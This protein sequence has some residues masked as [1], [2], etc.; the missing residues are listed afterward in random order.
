MKKMIF[1]VSLLTIFAA[2]IT[3]CGKKCK[4]CHA[5]IMGVEGPAQELCGDDLKKAEKSG[6]I[7]CE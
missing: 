5:T 1:I 6:A 7:T 4:T 3:S 2:G